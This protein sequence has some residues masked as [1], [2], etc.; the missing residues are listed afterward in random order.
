MSPRHPFDA[1]SSTAHTSER[2]VCSPGSRPITFTIY[3]VHFAIIWLVGPLTLRA[4]FGT[5]FTLNFLLQLLLLSVPILL[6]GGAFFVLVERPCMDP[7]WPQKLW[8]RVQPRS[9][10]R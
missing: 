10:V 2:Q 7:R 5:D 3:L 8:A 9:L 4:T 6:V 1:R